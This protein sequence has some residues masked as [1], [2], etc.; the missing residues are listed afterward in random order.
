MVRK[1][2]GEI[3]PGGKLVTVEGEEKGR[4]RDWGD[5]DWGRRREKQTERSRAKATGRG[6]G[7]TGACERWPIRHRPRAAGRGQTLQPRQICSQ[8]TG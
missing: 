2:R 8:V 4:G 5:G 7:E 1:W 3:G 6:R